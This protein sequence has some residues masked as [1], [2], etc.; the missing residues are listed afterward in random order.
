M[1]DP[2]QD[3]IQE[4]PL[5]PAVE[6]VQAKLRKLLLGSSLIMGL[7]LIAVFAA[8]IYKLNEV[9]D[10]AV[11]YQIPDIVTQADLRKASYPLPARTKIL[12]TSINGDNL[13]VT[14]Q[15]EGGEGGVLLIDIPSWQVYSVLTLSGN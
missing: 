9:E 7:G 4:E 13:V 10:G 3:E 5:D 11:A 15:A 8:I 2:I 6:R 1:S 14:Y 12:S